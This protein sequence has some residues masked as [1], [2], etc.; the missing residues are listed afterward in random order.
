MLE[1][2]RANNSAIKKVHKQ[3]T[4]LETRLND[5]YEYTGAQAG[6]VARGGRFDRCNVKVGGQ[7]GAVLHTHHHHATPVRPCSGADHRRPVW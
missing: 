3:L 6:E 7:T 5:L 2:L 4:R 1:A